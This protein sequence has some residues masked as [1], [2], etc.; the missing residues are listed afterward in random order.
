[1]KTRSGEVVVITG[2]SS[3]L[4]AEMA[5]QFGKTGWKVGLTAR[6]VEELEAV[7]ASIRQEVGT[8]CVAPSDSADPASIRQAFRTIVDELGPVDLLIA[9]AGVG[10]GMSGRD[11][12]AERFEQMVRVNLIGVGYALEAVLPS[13]IERGR[14]RIVG[15][16]S[17][18]AF[19]GLPGSASYGATKAGLS[20]L[21]EGLRPELRRLGISVTTVHPGYVRTPM[22]AGQTNPQPFLM[23]A[24]K[25]V[26]II[27]RGI[28]AGRSRVDFPWRMAAIL[29]LV[30]LLPNEIFDRLAARLLLGPD[31]RFS[32][33]PHQ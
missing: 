16:S 3:G 24:D 10:R 18:A 1:L 2:A 17:L 14:G 28:E 21:L 26:G 32:D 20:A 33:K 13:M 29:H 12:S 15:I 6:R 8:A 19:R 30:R 11:F 27:L 9:N 7:A 5:R 31:D 25:A 22:T 4:G 23:D